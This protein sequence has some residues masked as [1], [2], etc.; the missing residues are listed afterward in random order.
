MSP[1]TS[2]TPVQLALQ[3]E[4]KAAKLAKKAANQAN[5]ANNTQLALEAE[6]RRFLKRDW[7]DLKGSAV[8]GSSRR[9][10]LLTWNVIP[11]FQKKVYH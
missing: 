8:E 2:L 3:A 4:R 7:I 11:L 6:R 9:V 10:K 5:G 1:P